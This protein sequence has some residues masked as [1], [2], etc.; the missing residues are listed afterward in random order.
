MKPFIRRFAQGSND[1]RGTP[2]RPGRVVTLVRPSDWKDLT[3]EDQPDREEALRVWGVGW[4]IDP[5][6]AEEVRKDLGRS[7]F[8]LPLGGADFERS[9]LTLWHID[10]S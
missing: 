10:R 1:H 7:C 5:E 4:E 6:Y 9:R 2:T 8:S 3:G